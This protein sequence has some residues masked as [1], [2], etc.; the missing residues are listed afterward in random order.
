MTLSARPPFMGK[1]MLPAGRSP[2]HRHRCLE[3]QAVDGEGQGLPE[4]KARSPKGGGNRPLMEDG[5]RARYYPERGHFGARPEMCRTT[6][7]CAPGQTLS[8]LRD[9]IA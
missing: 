1:P 8:S 6:R 3:A 4:L 5:S 7:A 9:S 2:R